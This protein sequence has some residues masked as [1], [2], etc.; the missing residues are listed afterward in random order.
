MPVATVKLIEF[1]T[2]PEFSK[3][4]SSSYVPPAATRHVSPATAALAHAWM[5]AYSLGTQRMFAEEQFPDGGGLTACVVA[6]TL[7]DCTEVL[8]LGEASYAAI[9]YE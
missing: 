9:V 6:L 8:A 5:V 4:T 2:L 1:P 7:V 3:V